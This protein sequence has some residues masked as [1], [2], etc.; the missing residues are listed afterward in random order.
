[1]HPQQARC[2]VKAV[3]L[4]DAPAARPD[5]QQEAPRVIKWPRV[6]ISHGQARENE[7]PEKPVIPPP[8]SHLHVSAVRLWLSLLAGMFGEGFR[9]VHARQRHG[10]RAWQVHKA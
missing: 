5:A 8:S 9:R 7:T 4:Q 10:N 2:R 3:H 6:R 1:M